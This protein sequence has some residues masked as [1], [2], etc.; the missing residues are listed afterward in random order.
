MI[1]DFNMMKTHY[2]CA[3]LFFSKIK[4]IISVSN[5]DDETI[6]DAINAYHDVQWLSW[7]A[8]EDAL[9]A[10][11]TLKLELEIIDD[12]LL[13]KT[14]VIYRIYRADQ[15]FMRR[16]KLKSITIIYDIVWSLSFI[17]CCIVFVSTLS[18]VSIILLSLFFTSLSRKNSR[19]NDDQNWIFEH[20]KHASILSKLVAI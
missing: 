9:I 16:K 8:S 15:D 2:N 6:R 18:F 4:R 19:D 12:R 14:I 13:E 10:A 17:F 1:V 3:S 20:S 5:V 11:M 7:V